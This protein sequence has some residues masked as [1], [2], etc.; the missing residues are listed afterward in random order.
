MLI[1]IIILS[2]FLIW[3]I[4]NSFFMPELTKQ[5]I[6]HNKLV[7]ILIP[8]R[9]EE[10]NV[11]E[12]IQSL[13]KLTYQNLEFYLLD[14]QSTDLTSSYI[15]SSILNN[16]RFTL[17][18]GT[19]LPEGWTGKVH[20]CKQLSK[21]AKGDYLLFLDAD[22]RLNPDV[23]QSVIHML[24]KQKGH[25]IT[26]FPR[27]P[28]HHILEKWLVPM[29]H[30]LIYFHLPLFLAN[31]TQMSS[32]TAAHGSFMLFERQAYFNIGGHE[33]I[34]NSLLDDVHLARIMKKQGYKVILSNIT[35]FVTCYMYKNNKEVWEGFKKNTFIGI[36]RSRFFAFIL[37]SFY[38]CFFIFPGFLVIYE[39]Y[40]FM[41]K[42]Y[43]TISNIFPY[44]LIVI[45]KGFVDRKNKQ[46]VSTSFAMPLIAVSFIALLISSMVSS[47]R[48]KGYM[49]KGRKYH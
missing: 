18:Y 37:I 13:K 12:L 10:D 17:L 9:N 36:G 21:H 48:K 34:K 25:L 41:A 8:L 27:F 38:F 35:S 2:L 4:F 26:G 44:L 31:Y 11:I 40:N 32:A 3:T 29:Q 46:N 5:R 33:A 14:D 49:W 30:F 1:Y 39:V 7:S 47:I 45:Q 22:V 23:I 24:E 28:V 6:H 16:K 20:A 43:I 19:E 42:N 15:K